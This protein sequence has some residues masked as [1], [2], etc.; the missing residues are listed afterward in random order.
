MRPK[1]AEGLVL[2][3]SKI[4]ST[5][6]NSDNYYIICYMRQ[7]CPE[8]EFSQVR[9]APSSIPQSQSNQSCSC[10][11]QTTC[12]FADEVRQLQQLSMERQQIGLAKGIGDKSTFAL[13]PA[14]IA[15]YMFFTVI[16]NIPL[17][18]DMSKSCPAA[19]SPIQ[20]NEITQSFRELKASVSLTV[21]PSWESSS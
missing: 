12:H 20:Y 1:A 19:F 6:F 3:H 5:S 13:W 2:Y 18:Q 8:S 11:S 10:P 21:Y 15:R 4:F 7:S 14:D 9:A 17:H 16:N